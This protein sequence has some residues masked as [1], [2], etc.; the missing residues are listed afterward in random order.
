MAYKQKRWDMSFS[1]LLSVLHHS[2]PENFL[3]T[4]KVL[5]TD[6]NIVRGTADYHMLPLFTPTGG[7]G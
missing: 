1:A 6:N 4:V 5:T 7:F 2:F 3:R